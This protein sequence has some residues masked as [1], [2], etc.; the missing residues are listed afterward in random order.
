[1]PGP[2]EFADAFAKTAKSGFNAFV[3]LEDAVFVS[4]A[5]TIADLAVKHRLPLGWIQ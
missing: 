5:R 3:I 2:N 4:N 1:M